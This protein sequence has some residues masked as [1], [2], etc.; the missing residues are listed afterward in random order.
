MLT[1]LYHSFLFFA[2]V[3][4]ALFILVLFSMDF[5]YSF[6]TASK[7]QENAKNHLTFSKISNKLPNIRG[8]L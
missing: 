6:H 7:N 5:S 2:I 4:M 3:T 1:K 8:Y